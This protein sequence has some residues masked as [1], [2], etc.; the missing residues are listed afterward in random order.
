MDT[1]YDELGVAPDATPD[2]LRR[3]Y[4]ERVRQ[5]HPDV[6]PGPDAQE[7]IRRLNE[8][9]AVLGNSSA[10]RRYD[11]FLQRQER[12]VTI[13]TRDVSPPEPT[14]AH[15][16]LHAVARPSVMVVA[17][18]AI[19]FVVTAYA[20]PHSSQRPAPGP[21]TTSPVV[22]TPATSSR[23]ATNSLVG[24]CLLV[25]PGYD[26]VTPCNQPNNGQVV[27][28]VAQ[29]SQCPPGS[30]GYQLAGRAQLVCLAGQR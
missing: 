17:V 27:A 5:L 20:G 25:Q 19:I 21:T 7:A 12:R 9:W 23:V 26:A 15:P 6:N 16:V 24:K 22:T 1:L 14:V 30:F 3:A 2:E 18:L 8:V 28:E 13:S 10:K 4:R 29:V 11:D